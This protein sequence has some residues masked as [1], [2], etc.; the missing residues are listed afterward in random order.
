[1][2]WGRADSS[3]PVHGGLRHVDEALAG[4]SSKPLSRSDAELSHA[5]EQAL[6]EAHRGLNRTGPDLLETGWVGYVLGTAP[7]PIFNEILP[8]API[9]LQPPFATPQP[10]VAVVEPKF[11]PAPRL[12]KRRRF[13][14]WAEEEEG[15]RQRAFALWRMIVEESP[16][17]SEL[18]R[19]ISDCVARG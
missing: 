1:M 16:V 10:G 7:M 6:L 8:T 13:Q 12:I 15:A 11:P 19:Q 2:A 4:S 5:V 18:G 3:E 14:T 17:R 9:S